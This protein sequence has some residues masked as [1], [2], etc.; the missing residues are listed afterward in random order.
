MDCPRLFEQNMISFCLKFSNVYLFRVWIFLF[1]L[2][3]LGMYINV[4]VICEGSLHLSQKSNYS[5]CNVIPNLERIISWLR[6]SCCNSLTHFKVQMVDI[7]AFQT[8]HKTWNF[9]SFALNLFHPIITWFWHQK[10]FLACLKNLLFFQSL[11][12]CKKVWFLSIRCSL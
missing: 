11:I 1:L 2:L 5:F 7:I 8:N 6:I 12:S 10:K 4:I 3:K 9:L